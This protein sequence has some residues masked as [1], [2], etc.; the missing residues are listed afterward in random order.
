MPLTYLIF[1]I[2]CVKISLMKNNLK[3]LVVTSMFT[4]ACALAVWV[5]HVPVGPEFIHLGDSIIYVAACMLNPFAAAAVGG[6]GG[7]IADILSGYPAWAPFTLVIKALQAFV[8][9]VIVRKL[10]VKKIVSQGIAM[11]V[12]TVVMMAGYFPVTW[13]M[14]SPAA[15]WTAL[16]FNL[17]QGV[18]GMVIAVLLLQGGLQRI[19]IFGKDEKKA[20]EKDEKKLPE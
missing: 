19:N 2:P 11:L 5:F 13:F 18:A 3:L 7:L 10:G 4:A 16:P 1:G 17:L 9:A 6:L 14:Y 15:A 8:C 20:S 12:A